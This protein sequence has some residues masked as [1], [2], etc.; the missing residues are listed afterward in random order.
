MSDTDVSARLSLPFILPSQAQKHVTHNTALE[1]LD[2]LVQLVLEEV[3]AATPPALPEAGQVWALGAAPTGAWAGQAG[4]LAQWLPPGWAFIAPQTGWQGW[5]RGASQAVRFDGAA[6]V[7]GGGSQ[8]QPGLGIGTSWDTSN[9]LAVASPASLLTHDGAGHQLKVNKAGA[10]DTASLLFQ[11]DFT[12]HAEMGLAGSTDFSI[13]VSPDGASWTEALVLE[14]ATGRIT[15][16]AVQ[17]DASDTGAGKL[18]RADLAFGP[19]NLLGAVSQTGGVPTGAVIEQGTTPDGAYTRFADGTQIC[20][21]SVD[22]P[23]L[24]VVQP[25]GAFFRSAGQS[26]AYPAAFSSVA[27]VGGTLNASD[28]ATLNDAAWFGRVRPDAP[29]P[30]N[31]WTDVSI[32]SAVSAVADPGQITRMTLLAIGRWF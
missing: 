17:T 27:H 10:G 25:V 5:N 16:A 1:R 18:A 6:W 29:A 2:A 30:G 4:Q 23:E 24:A 14:A 3:D 13:K 11:S 22:V 28:N 7:A 26:Y 8:D 31:G 20:T 21:R 15:G 32:F 9:R 19:G 12:G